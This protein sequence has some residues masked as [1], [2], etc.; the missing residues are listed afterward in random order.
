MDHVGHQTG[1][2]WGMWGNVKTVRRT[3]LGKGGAAHHMFPISARAVDS[4]PM[5]EKLSTRPIDAT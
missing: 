3:H 1:K 2:R 4:V 5:G